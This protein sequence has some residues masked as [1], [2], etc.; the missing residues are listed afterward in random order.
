MK[1]KVWWKRAVFW[2]PVLLVA[3]IVL[4]CATDFL[5]WQM[6]RGLFW[7]PSEI[8]PEK[9]TVAIIDPMYTPTEENLI[10]NPA[11]CLADFVTQLADVNI[12]IIHYPQADEARVTQNNPVCVL[13]SGQTAP[14]TDYDPAELEPMFNFLKETTLPV[15]GVCAGLQVIAQAYGV[16]VA[17]MGYQELGY[18][19]VQLTGDEPLL[20]ELNSPITVFLWHGEEVKAIPE[21]FD[22]L[23]SSELCRVQIIRHREKEMYG[24]QFHPELSGRKSDSRILLLNFLRRAGVTLND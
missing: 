7:R 10:M 13:I 6:V 3:V 18:T 17:P 20:Q 8:N 24:V 9:Q 16:P 12:D 1:R 23:G 15:F 21:N 2:V 5:R 19:E 11:Y 4:I 14:W 22:L